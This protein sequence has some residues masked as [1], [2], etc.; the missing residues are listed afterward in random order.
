MR[1]EKGFTLI[2]LLVVIA[3]LT[4]LM[5]ILLP[6]LQRVRK[7]AKAVACQSNLRQWGVVFSMY[8][9]DND[10][11]LPHTLHLILVADF[12]W[13][14]IL[15]PYYS[16]SNDLLLCP[17]ATRSELR[18]DQLLPVSFF[19]QVGSKSTAWKFVTRRP[20]VVFEGSYGVNGRADWDHMDDPDIRGALKNVPVLLDCA[21]QSAEPFPFDDPPEYDGAI[22]PIPFGDIKYFCINRHDATIN[23]LFLDW[24]VRKVGLKE[25]WA[26]RWDQHFSAEWLAH[27]P[28]TTTG[29]VQP[30]DWPR[31]MRSFKDY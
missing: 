4:L 20:E 30:E 12:T 27:S 23:G 24:S 29:G 19:G 18:P 2:E 31:W 10:G 1:K 15:R 3:I 22:G 14:Y 26:L 7:Q 28:W 25:L 21:H 11:K 13:P 8:T 6:A 5:A 9:E 17:M 16:D